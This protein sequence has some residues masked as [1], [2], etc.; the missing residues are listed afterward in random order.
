MDDTVSTRHAVTVFPKDSPDPFLAWLLAW[1]VAARQASG[2][3]MDLLFPEGMRDD[4]L[5]LFLGSGEVVPL[6]SL[7][8]R[9][10]VCHASTVSALLDQVAQ[11]SWRSLRHFNPPTRT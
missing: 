4:Q 8:M 2:H 11:P 1:Q 10:A 9:G 5:A 7:T 6:Q 3:A